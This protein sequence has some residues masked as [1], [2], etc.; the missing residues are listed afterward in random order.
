[1][2]C[3][4]D[5]WYTFF[6]LFEANVF[7]LSFKVVTYDVGL[8]PQSVAVGD[9]NGD[10]KLDLAVAN[11]DSNTVSILLNTTSLATVPGAPTGVITTAGDA[12]ATVNFTAPASDGDNPIISIY[13]DVLPREYHSNGGI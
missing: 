11:R 4:S 7:A 9:F 5:F 2:C 1:M 12:Q 10:G 13:G 6:F 3:L 8:Q